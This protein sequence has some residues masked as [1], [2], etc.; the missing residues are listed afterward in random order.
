MP[1]RPSM[2]SCLSIA[3]DLSRRDQA[4]PFR[5]RVDAD[6]SI[7]TRGC[8]GRPLS[9][10]SRWRWT[11]GQIRDLLSATRTEMLKMDDV[12]ERLA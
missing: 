7:M 3:G 10:S 12:L 9:V 6:A 5:H 2:P 11:E 1:A 4:F 8:C